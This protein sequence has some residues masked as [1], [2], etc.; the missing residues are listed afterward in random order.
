MKAWQEEKA[1]REAAARATAAP[2]TIPRQ[3]DSSGDTGMLTASE[4]TIILARSA[5][6]E[7]MSVSDGVAASANRATRASGN[8]IP[9]DKNEQEPTEEYGFHV[10][11]DVNTN[12]N[13]DATG[14]GTQHKGWSLDDDEEEEEEMVGPAVL[15]DDAEPGDLL[16]PTS[17]ST[18]AS[19]ATAAHS[20]LT[21]LADSNSV[22]LRSGS[23]TGNDD[24]DDDAA[25]ASAFTR[26]SVKKQR[27]R[28]SQL[29]AGT[30]DSAITNN[31]NNNSNSKSADAPSAQPGLNSPSKVRQQSTLT[32]GHSNA[33]TST[34]T[35]PKEEPIV[36]PMA[37]EVDPLDAFMDNLYGSGQVQEQQELR[38][39]TQSAPAA[40]SGASAAG[41]PRKTTSSLFSVKSSNAMNSSGLESSE[42]EDEY[43]FYQGRGKVNAFGSNFI[44]LDDLLLQQN[45]SIA[46]W[47]SDADLN[48][49]AS[50]KAGGR[51]EETD[52]EE[53]EERE[54]RERKEFMEAFRK[55]REEA[56]AREKALQEE[57]V[58][59]AAAITA[60]KASAGDATKPSDVTVRD[61][62]RE[63]E[64]GRLFAD[65][66]DVQDEEAIEE[67]K[68]SALEL[69][70]DKQKGKELKTVDHSKIEYMPFRKNLYIVP[71]A[72][73]RLTEKEIWE[74]REELH[75]NVRGKGC[76]APVE[77]WEQCGLS[78]RLLELLSKHNLTAPFPIQRQALPAI[79][80]GR[81]VIG[82]AK[83]GSGKT[84]GF[85]LPMIRHIQDQPPLKDGEGP[86]GL[87][88]APARELALQIRTEA[89]KFT[90][91]LGIRVACIYGK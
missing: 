51:S 30:T 54:E 28:F 40:V 22:R 84:L 3:D 75:I 29:T 50:R 83:T 61:K 87:I 65:E 38:G 53:A 86:I 90:K 21:L 19:A 39:I 88:M 58:E 70:E 55:A 89:K 35:K 80:C 62:T 4:H 20:S 48:A 2:T 73:G 36:K 60:A 64:F 82:V 41:A 27:F 72:L 78:D 23:I 9:A 18:P 31:S 16:Q 63:D 57:S 91:T 15:T 34:N 47:E 56:E 66:G 14:S 5:H 6:S 46:G 42:D 71:R 67:T 37:D 52:D 59:R 79:M 77:T 76:P 7:I 26:K 8:E 45:N 13:D 1:R 17:L 10:D 24:G 44:T 25:A 11:V 69:L 81:D 68:K 12:E 85:V 74:K 43:A 32:S 49:K 33:S